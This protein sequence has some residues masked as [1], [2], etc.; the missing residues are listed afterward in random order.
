MW[1]NPNGA[2]LLCES[3][4]RGFDFLR[5][6]H[7]CTSGL[8]GERHL[9]M[10]EMSRSDSCDVH[11]RI[12]NRL[13][14][15]PCWCSGIPHTC[16]NYW[17]VRQAGNPKLYSVPMDSDSAFLKPMRKFDSFH[18]DSDTIVTDV[19]RLSNDYGRESIRKEWTDSLPTK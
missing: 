17:N 16:R 14:Q 4:V 5:S 19:V 10:M 7:Q 8:L 3:K 2:G 15:S 12:T 18:R 6:P 1:P 11:Q 9:D 13:N